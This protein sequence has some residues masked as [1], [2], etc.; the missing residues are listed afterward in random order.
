M[1]SST[2][3]P[4]E[5]EYLG[6]VAMG[7]PLGTSFTTDP[8]Q[9]ALGIWDRSSLLDAFCRPATHLT[10]LPRDQQTFRHLMP[11]VMMLS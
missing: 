5:S 11:P 6:P 8:L 3:L 2:F 9:A 10:R 1:E 4:R 7:A